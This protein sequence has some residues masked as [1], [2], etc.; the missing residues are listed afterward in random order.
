[1]ASSPARC[2]PTLAAA[3]PCISVENTPP[4]DPAEQVCVHLTHVLIW[5]WLAHISELRQT[6][7]QKSVT[8]VDRK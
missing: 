2:L 4:K 5:C 3:R 7:A 1:M 8:Q 6:Q